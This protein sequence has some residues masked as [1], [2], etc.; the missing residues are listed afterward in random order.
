MVPPASG[1]YELTVAANDGFRLYVDGKPVID[2]WTPNAAR[3]EQERDASSSRP[4]RPT[5]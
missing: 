5:T 2:D 4:A 1:T 3:A